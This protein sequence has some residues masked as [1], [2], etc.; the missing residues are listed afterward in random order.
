MVRKAVSKIEK[1]AFATTE[2][3][4]VILRGKTRFFA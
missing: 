1:N 4:Y 3:I 2:N